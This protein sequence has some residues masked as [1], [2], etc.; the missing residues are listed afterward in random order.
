MIDRKIMPEISE[1]EE[2]HI[3][4]PEK[5]N[6]NNTD[7]Y[8]FELGSTDVTKID[9]IFHTD[10]FIDRK[11]LVSAF[12]NSFINEGTNKLNRTEISEYLDHYAIQLEFGSTLRYNTISMYCLNKYLENAIP[13]IIDLI[14]NASYPEDVINTQLE[15]AKNKF[16]VNSEKVMFL[17]KRKL[18]GILFGEKHPL[19]RKAVLT[20]YDDIKRK[21][22]VDINDQFYTKQNLE[23]LISGKSTISSVRILESNLNSLNRSGIRSDR[24][25]EMSSFSSAV[26]TEHFVLKDG[27]VQN[28]L[29]FGKLLPSISHEDTPGLK[30]LNTVMGGYFGSRLMQVL[31]EDKG[32]TYGISSS[33]ISG[34]FASRLMIATEVGSEVASE[35]IKTVLEEVEKL[36]NSPIGADEL[37]LA[38]SFLLG[39]LLAAF[40]GP[41]EMASRFLSVH[42]NMS[43]MTHFDRLIK[44][45]KVIDAAQLQEIAVRYFDTN[46]LHRISVGQVP[47]LK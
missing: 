19:A 25:P 47:N 42:L 21:D 4:V 38:K 35:S 36:R 33:V 27:S 40:D 15:I 7:V 2:I 28:A 3:P 37:K 1:L 9:F 13:F 17:A 8:L 41:F 29:V 12:A 45:I 31:R 20:D 46:Y 32:Y 10:N 16:L 24:S 23:I 34:P 39:N 22:L 18:P 43:D 11:K 26:E 6:I 30:V 5:I 14:V 44:T